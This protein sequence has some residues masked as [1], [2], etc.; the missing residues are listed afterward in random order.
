[1]ALPP[2]LSQLCIA[3]Q[4]PKIATAIP[5]INSLMRF[6]LIVNE[7]MINQTPNEPMIQFCHI[8]GYLLFAEIF[9]IIKAIS[10]PLLLS[11]YEKIELKNIYKIE[12]LSR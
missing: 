2:C 9:L 3:V 5:T 8:P 1:M 7:A 11:S 4:N 10:I 12:E 6:P